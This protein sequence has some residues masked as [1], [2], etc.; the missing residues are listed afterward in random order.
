MA[1]PFVGGRSRAA[2]HGMRQHLDGNRQCTSLP[3]ISRTESIAHYPLVSRLPDFWVVEY[4]RDAD[5][6]T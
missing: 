2:L 6:V 4:H 3:A 1:K 5:S